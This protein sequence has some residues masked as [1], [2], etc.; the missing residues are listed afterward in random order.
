MTTSAKTIQIYLPKG[1]PRG[2]RIAEMTTRTVRLIEVPRIYIND[3]LTMSESNQ[4]GLY[5]LVGNTDSTDKPLLYIGQTG[6]LKRRINQHDSKNFWTRAFIMLST[7]NSITQT[8]ALY[9]EHKAIATAIEVGRYEIKNGNTGNRPHTPDPLKDDCEE[10]FYTLDILLSTLGQPIFESLN[11][12]DVG[13]S[14]DKSTSVDEVQ[15]NLDNDILSDTQFQST[16]DNITIPTNNDFMLF[17]C[18]VK[19]GKA[20]GYY[21]ENGFMMLA[22]SLIRKETTATIDNKTLK[23]RQQMLNENELI[24]YDNAF[25][26]LVENQ[27]FKSLNVASQ[28]ITGRVT[29]GWVTWKNE[30]GQDLQSIYR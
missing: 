22:G 26:E 4:V 27:L 6:D 3:F 11:M 16:T 5:F 20:R 13:K 2:I 30:Q 7:N 8:H 24:D 25:Y 9:M 1:D 19:G 29:N 21:N 14:N 28:L 23:K 17:H 18:N 15:N 10:L 12:Y